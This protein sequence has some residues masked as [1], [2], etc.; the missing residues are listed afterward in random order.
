MNLVRGGNN[1]T[2]VM[3]GPKKQSA[4]RQAKQSATV[5]ISEASHLLLR[6]MA[7]QEGASMQ[8]VLDAALEQRRR[9][10]FLAECDAAYAALQQDP[11]AWR[12]YQQELA[13]WEVTSLDG[14]EPEA[15]GGG[16]CLATDAGGPSG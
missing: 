3:K 13:T 6:E 7:A 15:T 16:E 11:E 1:M 2:A 4:E 10:K 5:R 14:L 12:D 9:Q 8:S